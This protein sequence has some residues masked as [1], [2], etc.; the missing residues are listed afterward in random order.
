MEK[1]RFEP[2]AVAVYIDTATGRDGGGCGVM[3][4]VMVGG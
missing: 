4:N 1:R 3:P 2:R